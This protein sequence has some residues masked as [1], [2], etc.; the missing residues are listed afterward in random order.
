MSDDTPDQLI[1]A[2]RGSPLV[3]GVGEGEFFVAS[4]ATP[5]VEHTKNVVYLEDNEI[6]IL[7][8]N[9]ELKIKTIKNK[10][11]TPYMQE[12]EM[13]L[14]TLEKSG[15][16]HFMLKEIY[17]QPRS[18]KDS[19]RGRVNSSKGIVALGGIKDY[20]KKL[21]NARCSLAPLPL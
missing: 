15:Y 14:E 6:A 3:I 12:L 2:K 13:H 11:K 10:D 1:A 5:I 8:R 20:E 9:E 16:D 19:M 4:D 17:E 7:N 18:I 21:A